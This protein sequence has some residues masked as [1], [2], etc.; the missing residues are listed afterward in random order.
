MHI[1]LLKSRRWWDGTG[2]AHF[3]KSD[4][5]DAHKNHCLLRCRNFTYTG[6]HHEHVQGATLCVQ[7]GEGDT[8]PFRPVSRKTTGCAVMAVEAHAR[9]ACVSIGREVRFARCFP[10]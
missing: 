5:Y 3:D 2:H 1:N 4:I 7:V 10:S 6:T 8:P 9:K